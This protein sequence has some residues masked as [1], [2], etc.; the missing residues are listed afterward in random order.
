MSP[1]VDPT[2][3]GA[4]VRAAGSTCPLHNSKEQPKKTFDRDSCD[5]ESGLSAKSTP[6]QGPICNVGH[7]NPKTWPEDKCLEYARKLVQELEEKKWGEGDPSVLKF[8]KMRNKAVKGST[9]RRD[10][11]IEK[12]Q[13]LI[14]R[15]YRQSINCPVAK[16][17]PVVGSPSSASDQISIIESDLSTFCPHFVNAPHVGGLTLTNQKPPISKSILVTVRTFC[18]VSVFRKKDVVKQLAK[19]AKQQEIIREVARNTKQNTLNKIFKNV[20]SFVRGFSKE[21]VD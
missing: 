6:V 9:F 5:S 1:T 21:K 19:Q 7:Y 11:V 20:V 13:L 8:E 16:K 4:F 10:A 12:L 14:T 2:G 15:Y 18:N 3:R 17:N